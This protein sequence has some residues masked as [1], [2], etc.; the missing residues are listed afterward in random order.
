MLMEFYI[1]ATDCHLPYGI[2]KCYLSPDTSEY[3]PPQP[4]LVLDLPAPM[5]WKAEL[6]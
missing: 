5:G 1:T 2:T 4:Q 3:A 6:T